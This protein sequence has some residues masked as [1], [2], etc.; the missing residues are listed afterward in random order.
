MTLRVDKRAKVIAISSGKGGVGKT[1]ISACL[2]LNLISLGKK[3]GLLDADLYGPSIPTL[4]N[5][6]GAKAQV[7][8]DKILPICYGQLEL[9]SIA[10]LVEPGSALAWRGPMLAKALA[11]MLEQVSW[12]ANLDYLIIDTPPGTGDVHLSLFANYKIEG[13]IM[14]S[15]ASNLSFAD[16][17]RCGDLHR[18]FHIPILGLIENMAYL[19]LPHSQEKLYP[20]GKGGTMGLAEKFGLKSFQQ[21]PL[22]HNSNDLSIQDISQKVKINLQDLGFE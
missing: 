11:Q 9:A 2:A 10:F 6:A 14:V 12:H 7:A 13:A 4:F 5:L 22:L 15:T 3:V 19:Q 18:K 8:Q 16:V 1:T 17:E 20:F 21:V